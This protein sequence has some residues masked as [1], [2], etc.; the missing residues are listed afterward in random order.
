MAL[1]RRARAWGLGVGLVASLLVT[2][3][4][5]QLPPFA[6]LTALGFNQVL[7][8]PALAIGYAATFVLLARRPLWARLFAPLAAYGRV[9]LSVYLLQSVICGLLFYGSGLGLVLEVAPAAALTL[10]L[11]IN[12][13]LMAASAA[14]LR[15]FRY[16]PVEWVWRSLTL[17]RRQPFLAGAG[18]TAD[19]RQGAPAGAALRDA[20]R[21]GTPFAARRAPGPR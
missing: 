11:F 7:A 4:Y 5:T 18:A 15:R 13:A 16:G 8:G 3:A 12:A 20:P 14:W 6:A 17:G 10:A 19:P 9:A 2:L 1:L 21:R